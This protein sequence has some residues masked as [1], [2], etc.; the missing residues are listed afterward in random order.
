[1]VHAKPWTGFGLGTF[2]TAYPAYASIDF[3]AV[4][5]HAHN[6][7]AEWAADGGIP[8][9]LLLLSIA[10][11]SIPRALRSV[12]GIGIVAVFVHGMVDFPLQKPVLELWL[13]VLLGALAA[14]S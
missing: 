7:W 5:N 1:M 9:A 13:F 12:W 10:V 11:W 2:P 6:D 3:G 14:E 8:F 4:V